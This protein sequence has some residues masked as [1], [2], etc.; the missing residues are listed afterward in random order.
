ME[1]FRKIIAGLFFASI[2]SMVILFVIKHWAASLIAFA[3]AGLCFMEL[4]MTSK[5]GDD[6]PWPWWWF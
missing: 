6:E 5:K 3:I 2:A 1:T 4:V